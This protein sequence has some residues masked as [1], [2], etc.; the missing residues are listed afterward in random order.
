MCDALNEEAIAR[1]R[2]RKQREAKPLAVMF[3]D[4]TEVKKFCY[5]DVDRGKR[6][7]IVEKAHSYPEA[8]KIP[9]RFS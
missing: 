8:E 2:Q 5:I 4:L 7:R 3:R 9:L 6:I 1:L